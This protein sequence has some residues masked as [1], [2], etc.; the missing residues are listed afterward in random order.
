MNIRPINEAKLEADQAQEDSVF[1]R[2]AAGG[3]HLVASIK[4]SSKYFGQCKEGARFPVLIQPWDDRCADK[5]IVGG[6]PG[7]QY[8]LADVNLFAVVGDCQVKLT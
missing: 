6:G 7:G 4:R 5:Y 1:R 8:R 2:R 3:M